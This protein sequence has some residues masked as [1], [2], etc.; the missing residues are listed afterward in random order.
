MTYV[1]SDDSPS[2]PPSVAPSRISSLLSAASWLPS[3]S[4]LLLL[5]RLPGL[6]C[7]FCDTHVLSFS[8]YRPCNTQGDQQCQN[9]NSF[10]SNFPFDF[11][12]DTS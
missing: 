8:G 2:F 6:A 9:S 12:N 1:W 3:Y 5:V 4:S 7:T 10:H 11:K